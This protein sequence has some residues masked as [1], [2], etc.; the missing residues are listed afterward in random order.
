[1]V[2]D[3]MSLSPEDQRFLL[4]LARETIRRAAE[5]RKLPEVDPQSLSP[6]LRQERACFVTL[7]CGGELRGC[8]GHLMPSAP[9]YRA[10]M[11]NARNAATRDF[12]FPPVQPEEVDRL[13]VEISVLWPAEKLPRR[14]GDE[15]ELLNRLR[16][17]VDGVMIRLGG[18]RATFLPQVW[19]AVPDKVAFLERLC[20]KA[21]LPVDAWRDPGVEIKVYEVTAFEDPPKTEESDRQHPGDAPE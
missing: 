21:G 8:I 1:M 12:R 11:E 19:E 18:R 14:P 3:L 16:P 20:Q 13:T 4:R 17:G 6:E 7:H 10:V 5:G 2:T 9:L 15:I